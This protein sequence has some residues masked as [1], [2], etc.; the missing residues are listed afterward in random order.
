MPFCTLCFSALKT[1]QNK[2]RKKM[3]STYTRNTKCN[4]ANFKHK[5]QKQADYAVI[6]IDLKT[7]Q[8]KE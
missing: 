4:I 3:K 7:A 6:K 2:T 1:D 5:P 8:I